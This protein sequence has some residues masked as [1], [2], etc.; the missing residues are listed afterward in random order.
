MF[1]LKEV[2]LMVIVGV[3]IRERGYVRER[4]TEQ[5]ANVLNTILLHTYLLFFRL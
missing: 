5:W 2:V 1:L 3:I 4:E